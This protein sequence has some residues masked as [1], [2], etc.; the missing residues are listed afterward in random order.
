MSSY[1][2]QCCDCGLVHRFVFAV[3]KQGKR[4]RVAFKISRDN[5]ATAAVRRK[6]KG[7]T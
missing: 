6:K 1:K 2:I 7:H 5:R 4:N 3:V